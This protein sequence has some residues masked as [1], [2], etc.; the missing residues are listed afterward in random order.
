M[1]LK[2][3]IE[4]KHGTFAG[5]T[6][7][8]TVYN[9]NKCTAINVDNQEPGTF[10]GC[11]S[12]QNSDLSSCTYIGKFAFG[13]SDYF[14]GTCT[15][16]TS[17]KLAAGV[18]IQESAFHGCTNLSRVDNI[19]QCR[20]IGNRAFYGCESL[21]N[22]DVSGAEYIGYEAFHDTSLET[23]K[24]GNAQFAD[25]ELG[26]GSLF[27]NAI[28]TLREVTIPSG[29]AVPN[30]LL[31]GCVN[32][33]VV[34]NLAYATAIGDTAFMG[35]GKLSNSKLLGCS[36]IGGYAFAG[37]SAVAFSN[38]PNVNLIGASAF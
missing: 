16:I 5:C 32:L 24:L 17:I 28:D 36:S 18:E 22:L 34:Y 9:L 12:L 4:L 6:S 11:T 15:S 37:C 31:S 19:K 7:L 29:W 10:S 23:L 27:G 26:S 21:K 14:P 38:L 1:K 30:S 25:Y 3:G 8:T 13:Y 33:E 20:Y 35:C 2:P